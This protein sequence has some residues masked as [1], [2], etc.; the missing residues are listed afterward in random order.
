MG[1][2]A[3]SW[4]VLI[5]FCIIILNFVRPGNLPTKELDLAHGGGG[6]RLWWG[7][8]GQLSTQW[9]VPQWQEH[10]WERELSHIGS[11]GTWKNQACFFTT[12][13]PVELVTTHSVEW[14]QTPENCQFLPRATCNDFGEH[15][16]RP[17]RKLHLFKVPEPPNNGTARFQYVSHT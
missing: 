16:G 14:L 4:I 9:M 17:C 15:P 1:R 12:S 10:F 6:C 5:Y 8:F 11:Q 13:H 3:S 2:R 7:L